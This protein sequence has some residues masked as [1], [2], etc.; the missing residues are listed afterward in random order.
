[1]EC[2]SNPDGSAVVRI[3]L[4]FAYQNSSAVD[5]LRPSSSAFA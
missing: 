3:E 1:M 4:P 2:I 5:A